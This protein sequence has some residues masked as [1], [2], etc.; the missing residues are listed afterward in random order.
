MTDQNIPPLRQ[1]ALDRSL[2]F[3]ELDEEER[4][5]LLSRAHRNRYQ[6]GQNIFSAGDPGDSMMTVLAGTV[7]ISVPAI[8][9]REV[10]IRDISDGGILGELAVV[11]GLGRSADA[12]ALTKVELLAINRR[13]VMSLLSRRPDVCLNLLV[14]VS[15]KLRAA[16]ERMS[17]VVFVSLGSRLAK[18]MLSRSQPTGNLDQPSRLS[19]SQSELAR[20]IAGSREAVNKQLARWHKRGIVEL[21]DGWII[22]HRRDELEA[23]AEP[24]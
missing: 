18:V 5:A 23:I 15:G 4:S 9:G 7:R 8:S 21:R 19:E 17:D 11:D 20:M 3:A 1:E 16:N 13:D 12:T 6:A 10:I 14:L 2:L 24:D 22:L